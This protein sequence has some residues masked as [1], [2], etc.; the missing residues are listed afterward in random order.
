MQLAT[1]GIAQ[2]LILVAGGGTEASLEH[3]C[4]LLA[5]PETQGPLGRSLAAK[6]FIEAN[7]L[8]LLPGLDQGTFESPRV[9]RIKDRA[10]ISQQRCL[11]ELSSGESQRLEFKSSLLFDHKKAAALTKE[12]LPL[13]PHELKSEEVTHSVLKTVCAFLNCDGGVVYVGVTDESAPIGLSADLSLLAPDGNLDKWQL[14]LKSLISSRFKDGNAVNDYVDVRMPLVKDLAVARIEVSQR[15]IVSFVR[16]KTG[17]FL[18]YRRQ[19]NRTVIVDITEFEEFVS[20][21]QDQRGLSS[22]G[23]VA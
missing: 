1:N 4:N 19:G 7:G 12:G 10:G 20:R 21:R 8:E 14:H 17:T 15:S 22:T 13:R 3:L 6:Q 11:E 9:I 18:C 5:I 23:G 16:D 2:F